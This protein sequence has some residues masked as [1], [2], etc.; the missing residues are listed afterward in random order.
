LARLAAASLSH[1]ARDLGC[2]PVAMALLQAD[3][4]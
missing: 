4:G 2:V 1:A 3:S